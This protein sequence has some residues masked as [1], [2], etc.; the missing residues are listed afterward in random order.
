MPKTTIQP[1]R[2]NPMK[3]SMKAV[4]VGLVLALSSRLAP[5][6]TFIFTADAFGNGTESALTTPPV[7][8]MPL[9]SEFIP[10]PSGQISSDVLAYIM[11]FQVTAGD[12][13]LMD[14]SQPSVPL[15]LIRFLSGPQ[16][17][18]IFYSQNNGGLPTANNPVQ[19]N[20]PENGETAWNP[21]SGEVGSPMAP[22]AGI[23]QY[24]FLTSTPEPGTMA[25]M[26]AGVGGLA[27]FRKFKR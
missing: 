7:I 14:A 9:Q 13:E 6:Q 20:A 26:L 17:L 5:A 19:I 1:Q 21:T 4:I 27:M 8:R 3:Q 2:K 15:D 18:M 16:T 11:P 25:M 12:V 23:C 10:D 22:M 24:N